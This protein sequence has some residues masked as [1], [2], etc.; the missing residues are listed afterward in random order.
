MKDTVLKKEARD[1]NAMKGPF[2]TKMSI[3]EVSQLKEKID[4]AVEEFKQQN[5]TK[6]KVVNIQENNLN[7][8]LFSEETKEKYT[9][10]ER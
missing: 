7:R 10:E 9:G 6:E 2:A 3:K 4:R 5:N 8:S 1:I